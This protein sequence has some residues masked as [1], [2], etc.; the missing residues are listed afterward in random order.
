M[1]SFQ[2]QL[3][4]IISGAIAGAT[5][6]LVVY[7]ADTIRTRL[8]TQKG[9]T[10]VVDCFQQTLSKEGPLAFYKGMLVP[11]IA[12]GC[13]KAVI[14][15]TVHH[16]GRYLT[17][18]TD[19]Q[20]QQPRRKLTLTQTYACGTIGGMVNSFLATPVELVRNRL[21]VNRNNNDPNATVRSVV[22]SCIAK[23]GFF[24][25]WKGITPCM[26]RDGL[27]AGGYIL[28]NHVATKFLNKHTPLDPGPTQ[29]FAGMFAGMSYWTFALPIDRVKSI[30][31]TQTSGVA[32]TQGVVGEGKVI[33]NPIILFLEILKTQGVRGL[34]RGLAVGW[35]RGIPGGATTF[36]VNFRMLE[37]FNNGKLEDKLV[38]GK[39]GIEK[40]S[41]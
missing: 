21:M 39:K 36:Y 9:Y 40:R 4:P 17:R 29:I 31:Q 38:G 15:G 28:G 27:G 20:E 11:F 13:Y 10:G 32:G 5:S 3:I 35:G 37:Y 30:I 7:P 1:S 34:Y 18:P 6:L 12:Q 19:P 33:T 2:D 41:V 26:V 22:K 23:D 24:G 16:L 14:F 8:Q 25:L